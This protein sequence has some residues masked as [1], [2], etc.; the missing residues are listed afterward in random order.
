M[1][2]ENPSENGILSGGNI[3]F[4]VERIEKERGVEN[5]SQDKKITLFL[6]VFLNRVVKIPDFPFHLTLLQKD[7][8]IVILLSEL[9]L[10]VLFYVGTENF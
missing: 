8:V 6:V 9:A 3:S 10:D 7:V 4:K 2:Y 5:I 1:I